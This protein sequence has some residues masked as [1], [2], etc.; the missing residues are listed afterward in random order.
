MKNVE[1]HYAEYG[2]EIDE[3]NDGFIWMRRITA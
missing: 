3:D 1:S 2:I